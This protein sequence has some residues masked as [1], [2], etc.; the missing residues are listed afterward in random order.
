MNRGTKKTEGIESK[1]KTRTDKPY[2]TSDYKM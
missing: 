2:P 1:Q